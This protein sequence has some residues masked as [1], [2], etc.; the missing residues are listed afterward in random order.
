MAMETQQKFKSSVKTNKK[1]G[2]WEIIKFLREREKER[3]KPVTLCF[4]CTILYQASKKGIWGIYID[5]FFHN[6]RFFFS[7]FFLSLGTP[8]KGNPIEG[9]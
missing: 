7:F 4:V 8:R 6:G 5:P 1:K 3:K 9:I 2:E